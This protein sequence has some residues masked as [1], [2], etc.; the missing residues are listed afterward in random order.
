MNPVSPPGAGLRCGDP[1]IE[2]GEAEVVA[3][4][5]PRWTARHQTKS[6]ICISPSA[7]S[8]LRRGRRFVTEM[9][10]RVQNH[11]YS[12]LLPSKGQGFPLYFLFSPSMGALAGVTGLNDRLSELGFLAPFRCVASVSMVGDLLTSWAFEMEC[13]LGWYVTTTV[14]PTVDGIRRSA[15]S[16]HWSHLSSACRRRLGDGP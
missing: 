5:W 7:R 4:G 12:D 8:T 6:L 2:T 10:N 16:A 14:R 13:S 15:L 3:E 9:R 1:V 11:P